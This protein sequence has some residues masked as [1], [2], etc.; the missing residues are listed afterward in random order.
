MSLS[1]QKSPAARMSGSVRMEIAAGIDGGSRA[2]SSVTSGTA[3]DI[4]VATS[5]SPPVVSTSSRDSTATARERK[6]AAGIVSVTASGWAMC[7]SPAAV[8]MALCGSPVM[9]MVRR[10]R[11][12]A[13]VTA[14]TVAAVR[15]D[16]E[17]ATRVSIRGGRKPVQATSPADAAR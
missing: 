14:A 16:W 5:R 4:L 10:P 15:P 11:S 7:T 3:A 9:A 8:T 6:P 17:T 2:A 1:D 13:V 12:A